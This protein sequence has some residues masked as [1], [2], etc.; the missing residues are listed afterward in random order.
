VLISAVMEKPTVFKIVLVHIYKYANRLKSVIVKAMHNG[1]INFLQSGRYCM[2]QKI[3]KCI[4]FKEL[5][6]VSYNIFNNK[7][8]VIIE[9]LGKPLYSDSEI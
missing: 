1:V 3:F 5:G 6:I 8:L 2:L 9:T 7:L 4:L